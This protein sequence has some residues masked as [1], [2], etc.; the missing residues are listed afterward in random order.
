MTRTGESGTVTGLFACGT[1]RGDEAFESQRPAPVRSWAGGVLAIITSRLAWLTIAAMAGV[2]LACTAAP[3]VAAEKPDLVP[4]PKSIELR[5]GRMELTSGST[6]VATDA[7]L[8]PLAGVL[9]QDIFLLTDGWL[10][11]PTA[12]GQAHPGDIVLRLDP[13]VAGPEAYRLGVGEHAEIKAGTYRGAAWGEFTLVQAMQLQGNELSLPHMSIADEPAVA[14]RFVMI[15][16]ARHFVDIDSL[17]QLVDT[18]RFY[19]FSTMHLWLE[20]RAGFLKDFPK[21]PADYTRE[22][23]IELSRYASQRGVSIAPEIDVPGHA[24]ALSRAYPECFGAL[25]AAGNRVALSCNNIASESFYEGMEKIYR[26]MREIFPD[27]AYWFLG[28]DEVS[29][30]S[31]PRA[32]GY[33]DFLKKHN[34]EKR[35]L[36]YAANRLAQIVKGLG[37]TTPICWWAGGWHTEVPVG[38]ILWVAAAEAA[39]RNQLPVVEYQLLSFAKVM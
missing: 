17:K 18:M 13:A 5:E 27:S 8:A 26:G 6:I 28:F 9:Q 39:V 30:A 14:G 11:L 37:V 3:A 25:D 16:A 24:P 21:L 7:K 10:R 32:P 15:D 19:K 29:T 2:F 23:L 36:P 20:D 33:E 4:W 12:T 34:L 22:E 35:A 38:R 1:P 31:L